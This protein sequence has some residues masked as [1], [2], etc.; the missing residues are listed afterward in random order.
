M[1]Y[2]VEYI[3][4]LREELKKAMGCTEPIAISYLACIAKTLL[5]RMPAKVKIY[6]SGNILKNVKSVVVPN[7]GGLRGIRA[8]VAIGMIGGEAE[9]R[10]ECLCHVTKENKKNCLE[11]LKNADIEVFASES[12]FIFDIHI[13]MT[14]GKDEVE[15]R[16]VDNHTNLVLLR[17]NDTYEVNKKMDHVKKISDLTDHKILNVTE[18]YEFANQVDIIGLKDMLDEQI[19]CNMKIA[20]AGLSNSFGANIGSTIL[21][22]YPNDISTKAR[23]YAAAA[24]DARM[25]GCELPVV[26]NSGSG[27]QGITC[28]IPVI[29]YAREL[30]CS[31]EQLYRALILSNLLTIHIKTGIGRLS[32]FCG[33]VAAGCAAGAAIAY[34]YGESFEIISNTLINSLAIVSG[35]ICDGAKASCAAKI[36]ASVDAGILG[37]QLCKEGNP[38]H[39][40]DGIVPKSVEEMIHN[41]GELASLGMAETDK[42]MIH[43]MLEN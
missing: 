36:G 2:E 40:G 23:A 12:E 5:G 39:S 26:I 20:E 16:I 32:A 34:L 3:Q 19:E 38:F 18:I 29:V 37:Y 14:E 7:T 41:I 35:I 31:K 27:N 11:F 6:V 43:L 30:H 8:A 9:S 24:S 21:K 13:F 1:R 42:E 10:L 33:A 17:K 15:A 28:S 22:C 4:I 25:N